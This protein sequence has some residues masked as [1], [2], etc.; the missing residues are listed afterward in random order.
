[1]N[2]HC[3]TEHLSRRGEQGTQGNWDIEQFTLQNEVEVDVPNQ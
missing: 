1:M 3:D 2:K